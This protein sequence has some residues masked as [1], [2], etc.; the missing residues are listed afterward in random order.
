[1]F[2]KTYPVG[3]SMTILVRAHADLSL[4]G[5]DKMEVFPIDEGRHA[6]VVQTEGE[7]LRVTFADDGE[8]LV[9]T[10]ASVQVERVSGDAHIRNLTGKLA[11]ERV[12][13]DLSVQNVAEA[14][15]SNIG[16]DCEVLGVTRALAIH[17]VGGDLSA[18]GLQGAAAVSNVGGDAN[19][20]L[21]GGSLDIKAGGDICLTMAQTG[22]QTVSARAGGDLD[23]YM[24]Q[25][26]SA[27]ISVISRGEDIRL[28]VDGGKQRLEQQAY[29]ATL[30]EGT[31]K[32]SLQA[33]GDVYISDEPHE[34]ESFAS[35]AA[36]LEEYW[37]DL[38]ESREER[39]SD[40]D[41]EGFMSGEDISRR[42]NR[43]VE[44]AMRRA[45]ER[46]AAAMKRVEERT[47][48]MGRDG[49]VPPIPPVGR[50]RKSILIPEPPTP[51][52]PPK[53]P[54]P[55]MPPTAPMPPGGKPVKNVVSEEERMLILTMLQEKKITAEEAAKL[56][57]ALE[58]S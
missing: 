23:L 16:G 44:E 52:T 31:A 5:W 46:I 27:V 20:V 41:D 54:A 10:G 43:H 37:Q 40:S 4:Q 30:G 39:E 8:L 49:M 17:R 18:E 35:I 7:I 12:G 33:G 24:S 56:L 36:N 53:S 6:P 19:L 29:Q 15:V 1:M 38:E 50:P 45:D 11:V 57:E 58:R 42:V 25:G 22:E 32:L 48:Q 34:E 9:P 3:E 2:K 47:R 55:P 28:R 14:A 51:P 13:G 26:A 21:V